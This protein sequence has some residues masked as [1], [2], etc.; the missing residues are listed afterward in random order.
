MHGGGDARSAL[1]YARTTEGG[2][3]IAMDLPVSRKKDR[4]W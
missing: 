3:S 2:P 4:R 1:P